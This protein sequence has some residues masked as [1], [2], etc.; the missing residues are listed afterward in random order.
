V[1]KAASSGG[2]G[3]QNC[4][5]KAPFSATFHGTQTLADTFIEPQFRLSKDCIERWH[6]VLMRDQS[7]NEA[8]QNY[9]QLREY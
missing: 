2:K 8:L 1:V 7:F 3:A 4:P 9:R 5:Q 6:D